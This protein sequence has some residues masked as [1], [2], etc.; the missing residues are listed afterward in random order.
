ME[1]IF[2]HEY[3]HQLQRHNE[4]EYHPG[5]RHNHIFR[6]VLHHIEDA[7]VPCLG[8]HA[9]LGGDFPHLVIYTV[10]HPGQ[11]AHNAAD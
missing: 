8:G 11:I 10:K 3:L 4:S 5:D 9:H 1:V 7:A 2:V 6:E